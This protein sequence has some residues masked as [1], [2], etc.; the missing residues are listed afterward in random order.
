VF[1][2]TLFF[3]QGNDNGAAGVIFILICIGLCW[4]INQTPP[5]KTET[6]VGQK[7]TKYG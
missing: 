5:T 3:A 4:A 2:S 6:F 1:S 7:T